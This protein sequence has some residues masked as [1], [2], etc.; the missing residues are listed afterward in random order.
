MLIERTAEHAARP[1]HR[2]RLMRAHVVAPGLMMGL[3]LVG[4]L[5]VALSAAG[6]ERAPAEPTPSKPR[7][8]KVSSKPKPLKW[9]VPPTWS[10]ERTAKKGEYRGKYTIPESGDAKHK[11]EMLVTYL[12]TGKDADP[13]ARLSRFRSDFE[14]PGVAEAKIEPL[15]AGDIKVQLLELSGTYKFPLGP[16]MGKRKKTAATVLK[17]GWRGLGAAVEAPGRGNWFFQLVGPG[18]AVAAARADFKTM[19]QGLQ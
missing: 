18:D 2:G 13:A 9:Q 6:C 1:L 8:A 10:T 17:K 16:P 12:G 19:L 14:G 5:L 11:P 7:S 3:L 4:L 15:A